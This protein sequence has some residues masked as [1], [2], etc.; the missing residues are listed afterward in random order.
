VPT[1]TFKN[2]L[3]G[4]YLCSKWAWWRH[5]FNK[6]SILLLTDDLC[7]VGTISWTKYLPTT[8]F[9]NALYLCSKWVWWRHNLIKFSIFMLLNVLYI[10]EKLNS[11]WTNRLLR[12]T[13]KHVLLSRYLCSK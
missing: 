7:I 12:S 8:T 6:F 4:R 3:V 5:N 10:V 9:K 2:V 1:A 11:N 13:F